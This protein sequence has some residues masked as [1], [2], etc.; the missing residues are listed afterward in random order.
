ML[1]SERKLFVLTKAAL[2]GKGFEIYETP[3][4]T[5]GGY[6]YDVVRREDRSPVVDHWLLKDIRDKFSC[7]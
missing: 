6:L 3:D 2:R 4:C 5:I 7:E 1:R